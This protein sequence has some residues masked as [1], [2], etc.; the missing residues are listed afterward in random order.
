MCVLESQLLKGTQFG[1]YFWTLASKNK[2]GRG[3]CDQT[4]K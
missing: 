4:I 3:I 1:D 2:I